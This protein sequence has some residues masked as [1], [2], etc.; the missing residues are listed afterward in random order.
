M[1]KGIILIICC[2]LLTGC[3]P[4]TKAQFDDIIEE[5][6]PIRKEDKIVG[7]NYKITIPKNYSFYRV[8]STHIVDSIAHYKDLN[9]I[10]SFV[11]SVTLKN[12]TEKDIRLKEVLVKNDDI[13]TNRFSNDIIFYK[14][15]V[16]SFSIVIGQPLSF[17]SFIE[18]V[19]DK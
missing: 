15:G 11:V 18:F 17:Q 14:G 1:K 8:L 12:E 16:N 6:D 7:M 10:Q 19:F 2:V 3:V 13:V 5:A 4:K 9:D